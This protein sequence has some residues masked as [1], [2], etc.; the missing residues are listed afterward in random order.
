[1][2]EEWPRESALG[3]GRGKDRRPDLRG[4]EVTEKQY[5]DLRE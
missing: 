2:Q 4:K 3:Q 5:E 1:M